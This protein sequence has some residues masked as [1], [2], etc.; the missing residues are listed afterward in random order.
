MPVQNLKEFVDYLKANSDNLDYG[1][2]GIG[3][4]PHLAGALLNHIG[5]FNARHIPYKGSAPAMADLI[6]GHV[7][8]MIDSAP[9]GLAQTRSGTVR[10][11]ATSMK[12]RLPQTPEVPAIAEVLPGY[13][14]YTWNAMLVPN[15]TSTEVIEKLRSSLQEALHDQDLQSKADQMGLILED[16]P[17]PKA[18]DTFIAEEMKKWSAV[19][20][21]SGMSTN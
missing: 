5:G 11:I 20:G 8:F 16:R 4:A 6:G 10:L 19:V 14:A 18:L 17:D 7:Q 15:G 13:E 3:S 12:D 1:S 21:S 9:T 2:A